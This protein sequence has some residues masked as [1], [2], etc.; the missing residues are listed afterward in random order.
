MLAVFAHATPN[1]LFRQHTQKNEEQAHGSLFYRI[2][3]IKHLNLIL[4]I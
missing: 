3:W 1:E 2:K 4:K